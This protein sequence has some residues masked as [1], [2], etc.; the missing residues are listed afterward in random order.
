MDGEYVTLTEA[1]ERLGISYPAFRRRLQ[2][3]DLATFTNPR[4][5]RGR[6]VLIRDLEAYAIPKPTG[7][8]IGTEPRPP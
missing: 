3:G 5:Q 7:G 1:A 4:D 8:G 2:N 6:L